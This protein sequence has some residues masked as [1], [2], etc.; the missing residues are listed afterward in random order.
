[1]RQ[2]QL[3][4]AY[5]QLHAAYGPQHWWPGDSPW[6]I[7]IGAVLTQNTSWTNVEKAIAALKAS[8]PLTPAVMAAMTDAELET[9]I[10]PSGF[11][12]LKTRRLRAFTAWWQ[13][14][15]AA[16]RPVWNG[17]NLPEFRRD[18]LAIN[19]IGPETADSILLYCFNL[20][21]F[22]IDAYTRRL[23]ERHFGLGRI[24][25]YH[26]LQQI[27]MDNLPTDPAIYNEYHAL[28]VRAAKEGCRKSGC[29]AECVLKNFPE[30]VLRS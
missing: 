26:H 1:M 19:G 2:P 9:A 30:T 5:E 11:F 22:V 8:G 17:R 28:I 3:L 6:E 7:G 4:A 10:M 13:S 25:D 24:D 21:V 20:P 18:L 14:N 16:D 29:N 15:T 27:F 23:A 12:R